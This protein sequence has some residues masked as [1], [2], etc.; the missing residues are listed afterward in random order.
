MENFV[1]YFQRILGLLIKT[2]AIQCDPERMGSI[3]PSFYDL[4]GETLW[5]CDYE[6]FSQFTPTQL[7]Q[8]DAY[9]EMELYMDEVRKILDEG[10]NS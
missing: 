2:G 6:I 1:R 5:V 8:L 9:L 10:S 3:V 7:K 4:N